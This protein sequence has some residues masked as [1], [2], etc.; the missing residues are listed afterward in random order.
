MLSATQSAIHNVTPVRM[1]L[2]LSVIAIVIFWRE[3][4]RLILVALAASIVAL[5]GLGLISLAGFIH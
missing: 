5:L 2:I 3:I 1:I 4:V